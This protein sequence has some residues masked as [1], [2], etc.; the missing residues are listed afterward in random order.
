VGLLLI[1]L[2]NKDKLNNY[3]SQEM[4]KQTDTE[5]KLNIEEF[6]Q[7]NYNYTKTGQEFDF[8]LLEFGSTG[9][10]MCKLM[11]PILEDIK[12]SKIAKVNVDFLHIMKAENQDLM[13]YYGISAV[14]MQ[15]LLDKRGKEL[16]RH[17]GVIST[18]DLEA[19]FIKHKHSES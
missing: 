3:I 15:I 1:A 9:C 16:F 7:L 12:T 17:Y 19:K 8:T 11:E 14:P 18:A 4:Q 6:V 13:K 2:F 5:L 10:T